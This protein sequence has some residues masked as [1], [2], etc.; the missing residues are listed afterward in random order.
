MAILNTF[1]GSG[2]G[3]RIPLE[4]PTGFSSSIG[5]G[6]AV[7]SW[8]D[9]VDKVA[10]PG[11]ETVAEW[12]YTLVVRKAG[13]APLSPTD[14]YQVLRTTSR[15]QYASG[16]TDTGLDNDVTYYYAIYAYTTLGVPSEPLIGNA[17]PTFFASISYKQTINLTFPNDSG[18]ADP[19]ST[20]GSTGGRIYF[21]QYSSFTDE[22]EVGGVTYDASLVRSEYVPIGR[23][24]DTARIGNK[25]IFVGGQIRYTE[26]TDR[27]YADYSIDGNGVQTVIKYKSQ[28]T[29]AFTIADVNYNCAYAV[30]NSGTSS[31]YRYSS[32]LVSSNISAPPIGSWGRSVQSSKYYAI[33]SS[34]ETSSS[35]KP[36][37]FYFYN[38]SGTRST[39]DLPYAAGDTVGMSRC[40]EYVLIY[41]THLYA[42]DKNRVK[43]DLGEM[44][45]SANSGRTQDVQTNGL[46]VVYENDQ[47][48]HIDKHLVNQGAISGTSGKVPRDGNRCPR[49]G[50]Y[51]IIAPEYYHYRYFTVLEN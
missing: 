46:G 35:S 14:G 1:S 43:Q 44:D 19:N 6:T 26:D 4:A 10:T 39:L 47:L 30:K 25:A 32:D 41:G 29:G 28:N 15:N 22:D 13:S 3:I 23:A 40:D 37:I 49:L 11:G 51:V 34:A 5:D 27:P 21:I 9:P 24:T 50:N 42:V 2:G 38:E 36:S 33:F 17:T 31:G 45:F 7:I 48:Y 20:V 16:Y 8:T 12:N 18:M